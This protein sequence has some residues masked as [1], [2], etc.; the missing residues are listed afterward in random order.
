[1]APAMVWLRAAAVT[2]NAERDQQ[3]ADGERGE[4]VGRSRMPQA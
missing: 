3:L 4:A 2:D 1:M